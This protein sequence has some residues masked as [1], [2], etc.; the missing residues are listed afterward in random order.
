MAFEVT[1]DL[2]NGTLANADK[3]QENF[4]D[5]QD[6]IDTMDAN[7]ATN[8]EGSKLVLLGTSSTITANWLTLTGL[9]T[10]DYDFLIVK[11]FIHTS[12]VTSN[13]DTSM[14][15]RLNE[16]ETSVYDTVITSNGSASSEDAS[17]NYA[18]SSPAYTTDY[19]SG[20]FTITNISAKP[21]H[22]FGT[23][24]LWASTAGGP[25]RKITHFGFQYTPTDSIDAVEI[26]HGSN[27]GIDFGRIEVYGLKNT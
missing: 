18:Y 1:N 13:N 16:D 2:S 7:I 20:E 15:I 21:H 22:G 24:F 26:N 8:D 17:A 11:Y 9:S 25:N 19:Q 4:V 14:V 27:G 5:V 23:D 3:V 6:K 10:S 12:S